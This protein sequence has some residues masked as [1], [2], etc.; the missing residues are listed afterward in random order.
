M[1]DP[2]PLARQVRC[3]PGQLASAPSADHIRVVKTP[4]HTATHTLTRT[5]I[6]LSA[7]CLAGSMV[8]VTGAVA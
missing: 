3:V 4:T 2:V 7:G 8:D 6:Q 1:R 5:A